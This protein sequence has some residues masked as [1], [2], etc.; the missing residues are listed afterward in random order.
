MRL[1]L[2]IRQF[3]ADF[4][5]APD[6]VRAAVGAED[7][8]Y[9][10]LWVADR[11]I[12]PVSPRSAYPGPV[13]PYPAEFTRGADPLVVWA[14]A[15]TATRRIRLSSSTLNAPYYD[16]VHLARA[17]TSLDVLSGGR[18]DVGFGLG[19]MQDEHDVVGA[20]WRERGR[21]LDDLLTFLHAWWTT[22]PV[23]HSSPYLHLPPTRVDLRPVRP[24]GPDV[25]LGGVSAAALERVGRRASGWLSIDGLPPAVAADLWATAR[26]AAEAAGRDPGA[27]RRAVRIAPAHGA[28][29]GDIAARLSRAAEEGDDEALLD[30]VFL[31]LDVDR[32][33]ELAADVMT[34][35]DR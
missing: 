27:L 9:D 6:L 29:P 5:G 35:T 7:L 15:A 32:S 18:L 13:Q 10:S 12:T 4:T 26:R 24:G 33:L 34:H 31:H 22:N 20:A 11:L 19:W 30:L 1:G 25:Y 3:G 28:S 17:L 8:G 23:E 16:P 21:R 2:N 14:A